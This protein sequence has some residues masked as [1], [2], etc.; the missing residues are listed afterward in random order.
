MKPSA[1]FAVILATLTAAC[2]STVSRDGVCRAVPLTE[3]S[4]AQQD[5]LAAELAAAPADAQWPHNIQDQRVMRQRVRAIC[6]ER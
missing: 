5:R 1:L 6:G 4:A 2:G 3:Y